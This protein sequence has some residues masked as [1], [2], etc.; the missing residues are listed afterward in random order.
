MKWGRLEYE[1]NKA[2]EVE[3]ERLKRL[4]MEKLLEM[5]GEFKMLYK[6]D[7]IFNLTRCT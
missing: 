2:Y 5:W 6:S 3:R 7:Q 1:G 4:A